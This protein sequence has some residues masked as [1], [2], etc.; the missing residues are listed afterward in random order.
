MTCDLQEFVLQLDNYCCFQFGLHN[1][2]LYNIDLHNI[3]ILNIKV[4]LEPKTDQ[5]FLYV[6]HPKIIVK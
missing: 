2:Y 3:N 5:H 6:Q 4:F 1:I